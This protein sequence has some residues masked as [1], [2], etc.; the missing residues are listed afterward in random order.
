MK[1]VLENAPRNGFYAHAAKFFDAPMPIDET[2]TAADAALYV[3]K[4]D[5]VAIDHVQASPAVRR[6]VLVERTA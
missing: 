6:S 2:A 1:S 4:M 5:F 3:A